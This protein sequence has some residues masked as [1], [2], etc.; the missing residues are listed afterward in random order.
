MLKKSGFICVMILFTLINLWAQPR[1]V[2]EMDGA[3]YHLNDL[4]RARVILENNP[5]LHNLFFYVEYDE[6]TLMFDEIRE[7]DFSYSEGQGEL[8]YA[9]NSVSKGF[10][11]SKIAV[12]FSLTEPEFSTGKNGVIAD[13]YFRVIGPSDD[14]QQLCF[15]DG[16]LLKNDETQLNNV[17]WDNSSFFRLTMAMGEEFIRIRR[18]LNNQALYSSQVNL[19][20]ICSRGDYV[21]ELLNEGMDGSEKSFSVNSGF[22]YAQ[23]SVDTSLE[24]EPGLNTLTARLFRA[25]FLEQEIAS[26]SVTVFSSDLESDI[27]II[28]PLDHA[29]LNSDYVEVQVESSLD[30]VFINGEQAVLKNGSFNRHVHLKS[31]FNDITATA[32]YTGDFLYSNPDPESNEVYIA[33]TM[34]FDSSANWEDD[35]FKGK[36]LVVAGASVKITRNVNNLLYFPSGVISYVAADT[37]YYITDPGVSSIRFKDSIQV[38]YQK[39]SHLFRFMQPEENQ[40]F[41]AGS[42]SYLIVNGEIDSLYKSLTDPFELNHEKN[43]VT[44]EVTHYPFNPIEPLKSLFNTY[45]NSVITTE[46][47]PDSAAKSPYCFFMENPISL[48][49]LSDG[50]IKI[51]AYKNKKGQVWDDKITRYVY[52]DNQRLWINL[53]QPNVYSSDLLDS[54]DKLEKFNGIDG[55]VIESSVI[56]VSDEGEISLNA[57]TPTIENLGIVGIKD[58]AQAPDGNLYALVNASS[59]LVEIYKKALGESSWSIYARRTGLF[60]YSLAYSRLGLLLGASNIPSNGNSGLYLLNEND[61]DQA[62]FINISFEEKDMAHVQFI[63]IQAE[64][65]YLYGSLYKNLYSFAINSISESG[66]RLVVN[67]LDK[68]G[69]ENRSHIL[70]FILTKNAMGAV[71]RTDDATGNIRFYSRVG[72]SF[73]EDSLPLLD[74]AGPLSGSAVIYGPYADSSYEAFVVPVNGDSAEVIMK[75]IKTGSYF[76]RSL[77]MSSWDFDTLAGAG[78]K[79]ERFYFVIEK[80]TT[81]SGVYE[82][83]VHRGQ[84]FFERVLEDLGYSVDSYALD[85]YGGLE[86]TGHKIFFTQSGAFYMG[87][88]SENYPDATDLDSYIFYKKF[89]TSGSCEFDYLNRDI[90]GLSGFS[91]NVDPRWLQ[92]NGNIEMSFKLYSLDQDDMETEAIPALVLSDLVT[93]LDNADAGTLDSEA[94]KLSHYYDSADGLE[95]IY[96]EFPELIANSGNQ[97]HFIRFNFGFNGSTQESPSI[98]GLEVF[99]KITAKIANAPGQSL[100]LPIQGYV[101]DRTV[102]SVELF[103]G[104]LPLGS[105]PVGRN[106]SFNLMLN[107]DKVVGSKVDVSVQCDN[108]LGNHAQSDFV[109]E[110]VTSQNH[111]WDLEYQWG[112]A[113][114]VSLNLDSTYPVNTSIRDMKL[115]GSYFGLSGAVVGYELRSAVDGEVLSQG[116]LDKAPVDGEAFASF[117]ATASLNNSESGYEAGTFSGKIRLAPN[118]QDLVIYIENPGGFRYELASSEGEYPSFV[119]TMPADQQEIRFE[120]EYSLD[121]AIEIGSAIPVSDLVKL[122][123]TESDGSPYVFT[124][125]NAVVGEITSLEQFDEVLVKSYTPGLT[126]DNGSDEIIIAVEKGN[127]FA[128]PF[129]AMLGNSITQN[130]DIAVIPTIPV[131]NYLK[132]GVRLQITKDFENTHFVP[133]FSLIHP[134]NWSEEQKATLKNIPIRFI[135]EQGRE[136]LPLNGMVTASLTVN[137]DQDN[138]IIGTV[139]KMNASEYCLKDSEG[140]VLDLQGIIR[141]RNRI[142]W[143]FE[144]RDLLQANAV[145]MSSSLSGR[146]GMEDYIFDVNDSDVIMPTEVV[147]DPALDDTYYDNSLESDTGLPL[148]SFPLIQIT[149][150]LNSEVQ[151]FL[152]GKLVQK[153]MADLASTE[154]VEIHFDEASIKQGRN[155]IDVISIDKYNQETKFNYSFLYDSMAPKVSIAAVQGSD[156]FTRIVE[157]RAQVSEANFNRAFLHYGNDILNLEPEV[158][159]T[160]DDFCELLWAGLE[161]D[162]VFADIAVEVRDKSGK[163]AAVD[164]EGFADLKRPQAVEE[165]EVPIELPDYDGEPMVAH[166]TGYTNRP[167]PEHTKFAPAKLLEMVRVKDEVEDD[168]FILIENLSTLKLL[169]SDIQVSGSFGSSVA[170]S[171]L[172][173]IVGAPHEDR[174][175]GD[176]LINAGAAYI[177][178]RQSDGTWRTMQVLHPSDGKSHDY[179]G[180]SVAVSGNCVIIGASS[181]ADTGAAYIYEKQLDGTWGNEQIIHA[182]DGE[183]RDTFGCSVAISGN[184]VIIG[185]SYKDEATGAAY[186]YKRQPDGT[187]GNEQKILPSNAQRLEFF[188]ESVAISGDNVIIGAYN[189]GNSGTFFSGTGAAFIYHRQFDGSW[190]DE[191]IIKASNRQPNDWFGISV[192]ISGDYAIVAA[193]GEDG[194]NDNSNY[195]SG[196]A[197]I[198]T[199]QIDGAWGNEKILY[200]SNDQEDN[201][202]GYSVSIS[203]DCAIIGSSGGDVWSGSGHIYMRQ[204]DGSW[205]SEQILL[206][207]DQNV[208]DRFGLDVAV[209]GDYSIIGAH[210]KDYDV[211]DISI[212]YSGAA[213]IFSNGTTEWQSNPIVTDNTIL[214]QYNKKYIVF[215]IQKNENFKSPGDLFRNSDEDVIRFRTYGLEQGIQ[216]NNSVARVYPSLPED[217]YLELNDSTIIDGLQYLYYVVDITDIKSEFLAAAST[218]IFTQDHLPVNQGTLELEYHPLALGLDIKDIY[219]TGNLPPVDS[220]DPPETIISDLV[221]CDINYQDENGTIDEDGNIPLLLQHEYYINDTSIEDCTAILDQDTDELSLSFWLR[222]ED[223]NIM[224]SSYGNDNKRILTFQNNCGDEVLYLDYGVENEVPV[225]DLFHQAYGYE[226]SFYGEN[227]TKVD[228]D[229]GLGESSISK[230]N[231]WN[232]ITLKFVNDPV[233]ENIEIDI[234]VQHQDNDFETPVDTVQYRQSFNYPSGKLSS[235]RELFSK[236]YFGPEEN[237]SELNTGFYSIANPFYINR[238]LTDEEIIRFTNLYYE[239]TVGDLSY[240]FNDSLELNNLNIRS[241]N[242]TSSDAFIENQNVDYSIPNNGGAFKGSSFHNNFFKTISDD[243]GEYVVLR[244]AEAAVYYNLE[245]SG[246]VDQFTLNLDQNV[247]KGTYYFGDKNSNYG[248]GTDSWYSITGNVIHL[249]SEKQAWICMSINGIEQRMELPLEG[250]FHFVY[251][252]STEMVPAQVKIY[253]ETTG[254]ITLGNNMIL[255]HGYY[256]LPEVQGYDST[257]ATTTF[258]F[259]V[260]GSIDLWYKPFIINEEGFVNEKVVI[261]DSEYVKIGGELVNGEAVYYAYVKEE[262]GDPDIELH[263]NVKINHSWTHLQLAWD[264]DHHVV[265]FYINGKIA[266]FKEGVANANLPVF[267]TLDGVLPEGDNLFL[268]CNMNKTVFAEGYLDEIHIS[269]YYAQSIY[270]EQNLHLRNPAKLVFDKAVQQIRLE[271]ENGFTVD[272]DSYHYILKTTHNSIFHEGENPIIDLINY[273]GGRYQV[274]ASM[275]ING[276]QF[277]DRITFNLDNKPLFN[278]VDYMPFLFS[279][280]PTDLTFTFDYDHSYLFDTENLTYAGLGLQIFQKTGENTSS[281]YK[282]IYLCQ[283]FL[284]QDSSSW[285][286]GTPGGSWIPFEPQNDGRLKI[287]FENFETSQDLFFKADTFYFQNSISQAQLPDFEGLE[288]IDDIPLASLEAD[289]EPEKTTIKDVVYQYMIS[290]GLVGNGNVPPEIL[291]DIAIEYEANRQSDQVE[292]S[293]E[294]PLEQRN[295]VTDLRA[296]FYYDDIFGE[297]YGIYNC[298]FRLKYKG[299]T[300][301]IRENIELDWKEIIL[302][303]DNSDTEFH[304]SIDEF[305][306]CSL[307]KDAGTADFYL[308]Y[309]AQGVGNLEVNLEFRQNGEL[310][311]LPHHYSNVT[312]NQGYLFMDNKLVPEEGTYTARVRISAMDN[313]EESY[314][315][316]AYLELESTSLNLAPEVFF[317]NSVDSR[318]AYND[319]FFSWKGFISDENGER[320]YNSDIEYSYSFDSY[321]LANPDKALWSAWSRDWRNVRYYNLEDGNHSFYVKARYDN[322]ETAPLGNSF[323]VDIHRPTF[324]RERIDVQRNYDSQGILDSVTITGEAGAITDASLSSLSL[325]NGVKVELKADGSFTTG[326]CMITTDGP[327]ELVLTAMDGVG[328]YRDQS[329]MVDNSIIS[330]ITFPNTGNSVKYSPLTVV[331]KI[332]EDIRSGMEIYVLDPFCEQGSPGDY[333]GWKKGVINPDR[334][335]FVENIMVNPGTVEKQVSSTLKIATVFETGK[336]FERELEVKANLIVMPIEMILSTH[337]VEGESDPTEVTFSCYANVSDISSWSIDYDGDGVYDEIQLNDNPA[338]DEARSFERSHIYSDIK[339]RNP[340]VRV[341]TTDGNIFSVSQTLIIHE[342][343]K[344]ASHKLIPTPISLSTLTMP[345]QSERIYVLKEQTIEG[346]T[347]YVVDVFEIGQDANYISQLLFTI[348]LTS[349]DIENPV[350]VRALDPDHLI[351]A[352]HI[353][354]ASEIYELVTNSYGQFEIQKTLTLADELVDMSFDDSA[355][356]VSF[357]DRNYLA[358]LPMT[359]KMIPEAFDSEYVVIPNTRTAGA[360]GTNVGLAKDDMGVLMADF[361]NQ[362]ILRLT[363]SYSLVDQFGSYGM[364][365]KEF[366]TPGI[367]RTFGDRAF[368]FDQTR[369]DIQVFDLFQNNGPTIDTFVPVCT[370]NYNLEPGYTNYLEAGFFNDIADM[371]IV[372]REE[373][374]REYFYAL[375]L[376]RSSGKLAMLRIPQYKELRAK[377]RNNKIAFIKQGEILTA[378]PD[379]SDLRK[380]LSSDS[381]PRIE[382]ALDYPALSPDGRVMA[383]T[384]RLDLY[385]GKY[386]ELENAGN[387]YAYDNVYLYNIESQELERLD[388]GSLEGYKIERPVFNSNGSTLVFSA[389]QTGGLWQLYS[390]ELESGNVNQIFESDENARF[391]YYSPDDRFIVYTTDYDGDED[392]AILD[393]QNTNIRVDVTNNN[394][395]DSYPVW[396]SVYPDEI[397][398]DDYKIQSKIAY[399]SERGYEK[400]LYSVYIARYS[401]SDIRVVAEDGDQIGSDPDSAAR[402]ITAQGEEGDYP[403]FVGDSEAVVF[404]HFQDESYSLKQYDYKTTSLSDLTDPDDNYFDGARRPAGMKNSITNFTAENKNGDEM[405]LSWNAYSEEGLIY[406]VQFQLD[407]SVEGE[408]TEKRI[409]NQTSTRLQGLKMGARYRV[410]VCIIENQEEAAS[411][412]WRYVDIPSVVAKPSYS[413]DEVNPYLVHFHGWK[414]PAQYTPDTDW[415]FAWIID[416]NEMMAQTSQDYSY[417]FS[418]SGEK[419]VKLK[420]W[421]GEYDE[422][423]ISDPM[424]ITI[425][426][427]IVPTIDYTLAEDGSSLDLSCENSPGKK[428]DW[429]NTSW[430]I[431]GP[432]GGITQYN[433]PTVIADLNAFSRKVNVALTM[434]RIM[435]NG[436]QASDVLT[437]SKVINLD[438]K[439]LK[440]V[441]SIINDTENNRL[442]HFSGRDSLGSIDWFRSRWAI[443]SDAT[444]IYQ[445]EGV[446]T[447]DYLFPEQNTEKVY[448]VSLTVPQR[449]NGETETIS[450]IISV[451]ATPI[452]AKID[453]EI[454][455]LESDGEIIGQKILLDCT[456]SRGSNIDFTQARWSIPSA[457]S[458]GEQPV[459]MGPV[460]VYNLSGI[461]DKAVVDVSLTLYRQGGLDPKTTTQTLVISGDELAQGKLVVTPSITETS[462]GKSI[463][464]DVLQSTGANILWDQT[465]WLIDGQY[466]RK[467]PS[468]R[469]DIPA[470][471]EKKTVAYRCTLTRQGGGIQ[472]EDGEF[473]IEAVNIKPFMNSKKI[474]PNVYQLDVLQTKGVNIDW[475]RTRWYIHDGCQDVVVKQGASITHAFSLQEDKMGYPVI[476]EMFLKGDSMPFVRYESIDVEGDSLVPIIETMTDSD[477]DG[478]VLLSAESSQGSNIDWSQVKWTILETAQTLYGPVISYKFPPS[479]RSSYT[480]VLTL[481]RRLA[482]GQ[483]EVKSSAPTP[484]SVEPDEIVPKIKAWKDGDT[485]F[486]S[487]ENSIGRGLLLDRAVWSF[488]GEGDSMSENINTK[489]GTLITNNFNVGARANATVGVRSQVV[490]PALG[491]GVVH[492]LYYDVNAN[493]HIG[494]EYTATDYSGNYADKTDSFSSSNYHSGPI[495]RRYI[496]N[497][498]KQI[499]TLYIYRMTPDGGV[500]GKSITINIVKSD[501]SSEATTWEGK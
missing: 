368:V 140:K 286:L 330:E 79:D 229:I 390:F 213:Y 425:K 238:I 26:H 69:F 93:L 348:N 178:E 478:A 208:N 11:Q 262:N 269:K 162:P 254:N 112:E 454:L 405:A 28:S 291:D 216:D 20:L 490:G 194:N 120:A 439:D 76:R 133:D 400:D 380:I 71:I 244:D 367:I 151:L 144:Y 250:S 54:R 498:E 224:D 153:L 456:K 41:K 353:D 42:E 108:A 483:L 361:Y 116:I 186:I 115:S 15:S 188:G 155:I 441:I 19:S 494:D 382:G 349:L 75:N 472:T 32:S 135:F 265:Y 49:G 78:F 180:Y 283:D 14:Y 447:F 191:Q 147:F 187:W 466:A 258:A 428:I 296:Y 40:G 82:Y 94:Y 80:D 339:Q 247:Q 302:K 197:Y 249:D 306:L 124:C 371:S 90:E 497:V 387:P 171:D 458:Y 34:L 37:P 385:I 278:L 375:I 185:A 475:E 245:P 384:S 210:M 464:L 65:I 221:V 481:T 462:E 393:T 86:K 16:V 335:F 159:L 465:E 17:V 429:A 378:K 206:A 261:L 67:K 12:S 299:I 381:L 434:R 241:K 240:S 450:Q 10:D 358:E 396:I 309:T 163:T 38:Y 316:T 205:R 236:L 477:V 48:Q 152:N 436:Q 320:V 426:S 442:I 406:T 433:G 184:Y 319:V 455:N 181:Q 239:N 85:S 451:E 196:A 468:V 341:I 409:I 246:G 471:A 172:Y 467:G 363:D 154:T 164:V 24:L 404:E 266:A 31:G 62:D 430:T 326:A 310:F 351:I 500:E 142:Q 21:V 389:R 117:I 156:D 267:G 3:E 204:I 176:S 392:I 346:S 83:S 169:S 100:E 243:D 253:I 53:V 376:S 232:Y 492:E 294:R 68:F 225:L 128:I 252:N 308:Q 123:A 470:S 488:P 43:T 190:G 485:L 407:G 413:I 356:Y 92:A 282:E 127:R 193:Q 412:Q 277:N 105:S 421:V 499:V 35:E 415:R 440:P 401:D 101:Y 201:R 300:Y 457:V 132:K 435:V 173:A 88:D 449:S 329:I 118:C 408:Y 211:S 74:G 227:D 55:E 125:S 46:S 33:G 259:D 446:A 6:S 81:G 443:F 137:F 59:S 410:R 166:E 27:R 143:T 248:L 338:S 460:A 493:A 383:F 129:T 391:P 303:D 370:L 272:S 111:L 334:T 183:L 263:S 207:P 58:M 264:Q 431:T 452:A 84:V 192:A 2:I 491:F 417:E 315:R 182:S 170:M 268:G 394:A 327:T 5:G 411:S 342:K 399:V 66:G 61:D 179:F 60:G 57:Q 138:K 22:L 365:E 484:V 288:K 98:S 121:P 77:D 445:T 482:N 398:N 29:L 177:F 223:E 134:D 131:Y 402:L 122:T 203:G 276:Y 313:N 150:D 222:I 36:I 322:K 126:F 495:C 403:C 103:N 219:V 459:Q 395:R 9:E 354:E 146:E 307:D 158:V 39:D 130:F 364:G 25:D 357:A 290:I 318:I 424:Y 50:E 73:V 397:G 323:F 501:L 110:I 119:Y 72:S 297:A 324:D 174:E 96:V 107:L 195:N 235:L 328:N 168:A 23:D 257:A 295:G 377:V 347:H 312:N 474:A 13:I 234:I 52:V 198:Y 352:S 422:V 228:L 311:D 271:E 70:D 374:Y 30:S 340:R 369:Q 230:L 432:N 199:K 461:E 7:T 345:D 453:Y 317:T 423:D 102:K 226:A 56:A 64:K 314:I 325:S 139:D 344:E 114:P 279:G 480:A 89:V 359:D 321:S 473:S 414:P 479:D 214:D 256:K 273:P 161:L 104:S 63:R 148:N 141:G 165:R 202:F 418:T 97:D 444:M 388:L 189:Y 438:F 167:F 18:P 362:R 416:N 281:L 331:G 200:A 301:A 469:Y 373:G 292:F 45:E 106:G 287:N 160:G 305:S 4:V 333:S 332:R 427:D 489:S 280:E 209:A 157:I 486:L 8:L 274:D 298:T 372:V 1:V 47:A 136:D 95:K 270:Q 217:G 350:I 419:T 304:F 233:D 260:S 285:I 275:T 145:T 379:G 336:V 496:G 215:Q 44:L 99:K 242:G 175:F 360:M 113:E 231:S 237:S 149:K 212:K 448:S 91:F 220:E 255:N 251:D 343:I 355:L 87:L 289:P 366:L 463:V 109:V 337:A 386:F 487:A 284:N 437:I 293:G 51:V 218:I 420:T 476:V